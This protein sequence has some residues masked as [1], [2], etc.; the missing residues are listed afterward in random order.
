[1]GIQTGLAPTEIRNGRNTRSFNGAP[2]NAVLYFLSENHQYIAVPNEERYSALTAGL[3]V[4]ASI[5]IFAGA[6]FGF[7]LNKVVFRLSASTEVQLLNGATVL[8]DD[9]PVANEKVDLDWEPQGLI[10]PNDGTAL[11]FK[12]V[13][14][15]VTDVYMNAYWCR[16]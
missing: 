3:A 13:L 2:V 11:T 7:Q 12:N 4:G 6:G 9:K 5:T 14:G 10:I 8:Y 1:M 16:Y 15:A